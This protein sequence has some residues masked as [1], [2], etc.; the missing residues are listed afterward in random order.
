VLRAAEILGYRGIPAAERDGQVFVRED[1]CPAPRASVL[2]ERKTAYCQRMD[3]RCPYFVA[4]ANDVVDCSAP[5]SLRTASTFQIT[6][7]DLAVLYRKTY[8]RDLKRNLEYLL[9]CLGG[10]YESPYHDVDPKAVQRDAEDLLSQLSAAGAKALSLVK[11]GHVSVDQLKRTLLSRDFERLYDKPWPIPVYVSAGPGDHDT[12]GLLVHE[13]GKLEMFEGND[14]ATD[15]TVGLV[16]DLLGLGTKKIRVWGSH[17]TKV[18]DRI[19]DH[20]ELP[21]NLYVSPNR[22]HAAGYWGEDRVLFEVEIPMSAVSQESTVDWRVLKPTK[23]SKFK[24]AD[25]AKYAYADTAKYADIADILPTQVVNVYDHLAPVD[26]HLLFVTLG[27]LTP[28]IVKRVRQWLRGRKQRRHREQEV[29]VGRAYASKLLRLKKLPHS[30]DSVTGL[31]TLKGRRFAI[32]KDGITL[33]GP[34][35]REHWPLSEL[36]DRLPAWL[37]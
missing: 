14:E 23:V 1:A 37:G 25:T 22:S 16:N 6:E 19:R 36:T 18:V 20:K 11:G 13:S 4:Y 27:L 12:I 2:V 8:D 10:D 15:E 32:R 24:Y 33:V 35:G 21:A 28:S 34:A 7:S 9:E 3:R 31:Y 30:I 26:R 29:A 17:G 5:R